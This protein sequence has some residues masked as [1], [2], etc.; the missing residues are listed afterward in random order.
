MRFN[1][2][3]TPLISDFVTGIVDEWET[4]E[5]VIRRRNLA[6]GTEHLISS[7]SMGFGYGLGLGLGFGRA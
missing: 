4:Q 5:L 2:D 7:L 6:L 3:L 1:D